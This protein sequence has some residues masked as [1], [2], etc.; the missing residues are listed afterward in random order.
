MFI[1]K[2]EI[3]EGTYEILTSKYLDDRIDKLRKKRHNLLTNCFSLNGVYDDKNNDSLMLCFSEDEYITL[4][5]PRNGFTEIL[6]WI[7]DIDRFRIHD[8]L[9]PLVTDLYMRSVSDDVVL[10]KT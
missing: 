9:E 6:Y 2:E 4:Y 3:I 10:D 1:Q 7:A 8:T 5:M